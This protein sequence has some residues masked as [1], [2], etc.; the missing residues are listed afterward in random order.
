MT[1]EQVHTDRLY[2]AL[3]QLLPHKEALEKHLRERLGELF[4]LKCDLL[5]YAESRVGFRSQ[6]VT[7]VD[8]RQADGWH[9]H[10]VPLPWAVLSEEACSRELES[11]SRAGGPDQ[12]LDLPPKFFFHR[13]FHWGWLITG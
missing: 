9:R 13:P 6:H 7:E 11:K 2:K 12:N 5:L 1:P 10:R 3:D 8:C 4:E